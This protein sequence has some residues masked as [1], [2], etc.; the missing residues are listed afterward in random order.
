MA[1]K[2]T[3]PP[4]GYVTT[5]Q[6]TKMLGVSRSNLSVHR[7]FKTGPKPVKVGDAVL[8]KRNEIVAWKRARAKK[9]AVGKAIAEIKVIKHEITKLNI[10]LVRVVNRLAGK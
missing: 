1:T 3:K 6:A 10:R 9:T 2:T 4:K 8:Y 7:H 5:K